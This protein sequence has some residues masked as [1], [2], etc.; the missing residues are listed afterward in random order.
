MRGASSCTSRATRGASATRSHPNGRTGLYIVDV[1]DPWHPQILTYQWV[2]AGH[3]ATCINDCRYLWSMGP[4]NNGSHVNGQ[5]QDIAGVLHPEWSGVPVFV[6]DVRD[7]LHPYTYAQPVDMLRNNNH[8]AYTHSADVDQHGVVWTSGFGGVRGFWTR[9]KHLDPTTG[10]K[11]YATAMDPIPYAGGSVHS[12]DPSFATSILEHNAFHRTQAHSDHSSKKVTSADGRTFNK[13][14]LLYITQ[15]NTVSCTSTS[16]GGS[17]RF[18]VANLAGSYGGEDWASTVNE[19]NRFFI[20]TIGD[21]SAKNNPGENPTAGCSAHW[22]TVLG[23]MVAIAFYGQGVRILDMSDP[24]TAG[25]GRLHPHPVAGRAERSLG[26]EQR[27]RGLL[28]QRLHLH[29]GLHARRRRAEV[30]RRDQGRRPAQGLL[31]R[32]RQIDPVEGRGARLGLPPP[33]VPCPA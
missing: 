15:E 27:V 17:G 26:R 16:G 18:V 14:D 33:L 28:A 19:S 20:E 10:E 25:A 1:K 5:P 29:R 32:L 4:A 12:N 6:T 22:F 31:E 8:T 24:T 11:R 13:E 21:Y 3:T 2:P 9:G 7:P 30:H 23:D